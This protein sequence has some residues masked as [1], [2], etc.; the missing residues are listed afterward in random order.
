MTES[1]RATGDMPVEGIDPG[2][3]H[4]THPGKQTEKGRTVEHTV[5]SGDQNAKPERTTDP[6]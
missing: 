4:S 5:Q 6:D 1:T 2:G 3:T